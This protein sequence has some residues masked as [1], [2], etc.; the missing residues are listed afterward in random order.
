[1]S[2]GAG[3]DAADVTGMKERTIPMVL[4]LSSFDSIRRFKDN[5]DTEGFNSLDVLIHNAGASKNHKATENSVE[6]INYV[7]PWFLTHLLIEK[8]KNASIGIKISR[9]VIVSSNA[10]IF[11]QINSKHV[12]SS[13]FKPAFWKYFDA[14]SE[15][16]LF[17]G[18]LADRLKFDPSKVDESKVTVNVLH[19]GGAR[20]KIYDVYKVIGVVKYLFPKPAI[21]ARSSICVAAAK[22]YEGVTGKYFNR[23]KME[24]DVFDK[25]YYNRKKAR[26]LWEATK[27]YVKTQNAFKSGEENLIPL[28]TT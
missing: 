14:K 13:S 5:L 7:G 17:T 23:C 19:P 16:I 22:E 12:V 9:I 20:T 8:L 24:K 18:E 10:H 2:P 11:G 15:L 28:K 1:M 21:A 3:A 27:E 4:D 26:K 25:T 6:M